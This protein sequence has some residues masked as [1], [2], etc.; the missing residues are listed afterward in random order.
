MKPLD[1]SLAI[2]EMRLSVPLHHMMTIAQDPIMPGKH[3]ELAAKYLLATQPA[4]KCKSR[5]FKSISA[6][7]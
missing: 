4:V 3:S 6:K 5:T 1:Y 2:L 7:L